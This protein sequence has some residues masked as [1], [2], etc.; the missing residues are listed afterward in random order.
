MENVMWDI[1]YQE[2]Y[3]IH[4][5][6]DKQNANGKILVLDDNAQA[7]TVASRLRTSCAYRPTTRTALRFARIH[8]NAST[9]IPTVKAMKHC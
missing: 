5:P 7:A 4:G 9:R 6:R 2:K 8:S 3:M 1:R